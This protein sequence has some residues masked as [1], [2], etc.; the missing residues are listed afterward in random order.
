MLNEDGE[1]DLREQISKIEKKFF[2]PFSKKVGLDN[3]QEFQEKRNQLLKQR[4][5]KILQHKTLISRMENQLEFERGKRIDE[6]MDELKVNIVRFEE[7]IKK[8][9]RDLLKRKETESKLYTKL[10]EYRKEHAEL[11]ENVKELH[12]DFLALR[13]D[14]ERASKNCSAKMKKINSHESEVYA[15]K[16]KRMQ[17]FRD[18]KLKQIDIPFLD[19]DVEMEDVNTESQAS[20]SSQSFS[21][22]AD[23]DSPE[24]DFDSM[25][26]KDK[27]IRTT[28]E[29]EN[30]CQE[31]EEKIRGLALQLEKIAPNM[32]ASGQFKDA[33]GRLKSAQDDLDAARSGA[34]QSAEDFN[35][36]R[37][38][39]KK[40]FMA[41]YTH[42]RDNID[43]I[44]KELTKE[45]TKEGNVVLGGNAYLI[46]ENTDEPYLGGIKYNA[47]PPG[48][49]YLDLDL[50]SG[51]EKTL[52]AL[53]LVFAIHSFQPSPFFV[54][55]EIDAAL[56][57]VNVGRVARYLKECS[58]NGVQCIVISLKPK[59]F[60]EADALIGVYRDQKEKCSRTLSYNLAA[61]FEEAD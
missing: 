46:V 30:R 1:R 45:K 55:D 41:A 51:G 19:E 34:L 12:T 58:Q 56:D 22:M 9:E 33:E 49:R 44:Y 57:S 8:G 29:Y 61:R 28:N 48:K 40:K 14:A 7:I 20:Q 35:K 17:I 13:A 2:G 42:I 4:A 18:C 21:Q 31:F 27:K 50:L 37:E 43:H 5:D 11:R 25:A 10:E 47:M 32:K 60:Q 59:L 52:A 39:R 3:V 53:G 16:N 38:D 15:L 26:S 23:D 54:L 36:V 6:S 24:I